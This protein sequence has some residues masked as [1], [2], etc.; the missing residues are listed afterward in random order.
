MTF[1]KN[2]RRFGKSQSKSSNKFMRGVS[3]ISKRK[4]VRRR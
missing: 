1:K 2:M 4:V 3:N